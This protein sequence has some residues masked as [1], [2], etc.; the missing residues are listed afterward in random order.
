[1]VELQAL[2]S[3]SYARARRS[4]DLL[5]GISRLIEPSQ[6]IGFVD[7]ALGGQDSWEE[8][9]GGI[10]LVR[11]GRTVVAP[12]EVWAGTDREDRSILWVE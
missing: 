9:M 1:M 10:E 12:M 4:P 7:G 2:P 8:T 3:W 11:E 5:P 6:K